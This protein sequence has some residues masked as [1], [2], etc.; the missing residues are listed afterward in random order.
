MKNPSFNFPERTVTEA[1]T[2]DD[3]SALGVGE[4]GQFAK[5]QTKSSTQR[6]RWNPFTFSQNNFDQGITL[7]TYITN[8]NPF[9]G[10]VNFNLGGGWRVR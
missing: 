10:K 9:L 6:S 1:F 8:C 3:S 4:G 5:F 2:R 7:D